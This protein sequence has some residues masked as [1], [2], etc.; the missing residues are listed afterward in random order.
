MCT[1]AKDVCPVS[2]L[3]HHEDSVSVGCLERGY[4]NGTEVLPPCKASRFPPG[5]A[6][7]LECGH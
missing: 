7:V 5:L 2:G 4:V 6:R 3:I 1:R